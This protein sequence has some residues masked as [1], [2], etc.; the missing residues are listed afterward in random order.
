MRSSR[1]CAPPRTR[2]GSRDRRPQLA[3]RTKGTQT[4]Q[5]TEAA[6]RRSAAPGGAAKLV[7]SRSIGG[8]RASEFSPWSTLPVSSGSLGFL[9]LPEP[10]GSFVSPG[11]VGSLQSFGSFPSFASF[12]SFPSP[13]RKPMVTPS[14]ATAMLPRMGKAAPRINNRNRG[15]PTDSKAAPRM[16][17]RST[18]AALFPRLR[19][20]GWAA[21]LRIV[22]R[23]PDPS[24]V[25]RL[26]PSVVPMRLRLQWLRFIRGTAL[27]IRGH[28]AVAVVHFGCSLRLFIRGR[29]L[30]LRFPSR[31]GTPSSRTASRPSGSRRGPT[32]TPHGG[33]P[34]P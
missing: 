17:N 5:R 20:T 26:C 18:A 14:G 19:S 1:S 23:L 6:T 28:S 12:P 13:T 29:G 32:P 16:S 11:F 34:R 15:I 33:H 21:A 22:D 2:Q 30:A 25:G 3:K 7:T 24:S 8:Q 4:T 27:P 9:R 10:P 31:G